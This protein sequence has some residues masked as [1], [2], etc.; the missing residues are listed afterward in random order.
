MKKKIHICFI[1]DVDGVMTTGIQGYSSKGKILKFFGPHDNDG[2]KQ[3]KKYINIEFVTADRRG[4]KIS[5]KRIV[6]DMKFNLDLVQE[7]K[8]YDFLNKKYGLK[9][10]IYMGDGIY[11]AKIIKE[12][13]YGISPK[14]ARI[15]ARRSSNFVTRSKSGEGAVLDAC[16]KIL[17]HFFFKNFLT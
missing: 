6:D 1:V 8:R 5:K 14:N 2:L 15:E 3:L 7:N 16:I 13:L 11:D 9:N 12:C 4:Y 17:K 10:I